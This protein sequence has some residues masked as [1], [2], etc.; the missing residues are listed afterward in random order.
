MAKVRLATPVA[1]GQTVMDRTFL[2]WVTEQE[3]GLL[4]LIHLAFASGPVRVLLS[5]YA[6]ASLGADPA[7]QRRWL[8]YRVRALLTEMRQAEGHPGAFPALASRIPKNVPEL[9][10]EA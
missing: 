10:F 7:R 4:A 1:V 8:R 5:L 6:T 2:A 3:V 9:H